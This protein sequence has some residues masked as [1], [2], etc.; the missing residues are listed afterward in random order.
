M[1]WLMEN[2][3]LIGRCAWVAAWVGL[4][5]GQLHALSRHA[6]AAGAEDLALPATAAW[7]VP[8]AKALSPLLGWGDPDLV[9]VT[10]GKIWFP[11]FLA[12]TLCAFVIYKLRRPGLWETWVWRVTLTGYVL[13]C[14]GVFLDYWTQWT[15][16]YNVLFEVGWMVSVPAL[17]LTMVGSTVLGVTLLVRASVPRLPALLLAGCDSAGLGDLAGHLPGQ[18]GAPGDVRLRDPRASAGFGIYGG[19]DSLGRRGLS[20]LTARPPHSGA[21][22]P[23]SRSWATASARGTT[24]SFVCAIG[25]RTGILAE[26]ASRRATSVLVSPHAPPVEQGTHYEGET[27][28]TRASCRADP[29][30]AASLGLDSGG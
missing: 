5:A 21:Q 28:Q 1:S 27:C 13:A 4:A 12:F 20:A 17:L 18:C 15:G 26:S 9:Y 25:V 6:T 19:G 8:A 30:R 3:R 11:L 2:Q 16:N 7:A 24:R 22:S 23:A 14:A 10:Y 29:Y